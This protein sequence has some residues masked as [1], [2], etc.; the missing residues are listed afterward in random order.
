MMQL[1]G[2]F[3]GRDLYHVA[4]GMGPIPC[5][6]AK[7]T[8]GWCTDASEISSPYFEFRYRCP[9]QMNFLTALGAKTPPCYKPLKRKVRYWHCN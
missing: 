6:N 8:S 3:R 2:V 1:G 4:P 7:G 9:Y 5:I